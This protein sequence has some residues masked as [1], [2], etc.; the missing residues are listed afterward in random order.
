MSA[1]E[2]VTDLNSGASILRRR[3]YGVIL[4]AGGRFERVL[5]RPYP[6]V[7]WLPELWL[8]R[9]FHERGAG[10]RC[11][12]Y[13]NQPRGFTNFLALRFVRSS[14]RGTLATF[15]AALRVLDAIAEIK[16][17]DALLCDVQNPR[18]SDRLMHRWGWEPHRPQRWH[19]NFIKRFY[20]DYSARPATAPAVAES[21]A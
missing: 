12:L 1:F 19:R 21:H 18:I 14:A 3:R 8:G 16:G 17:T 7:M 2:T 9:R 4:A 20:G 11:L 10:D 13:Y 15:R 6:K 5:L